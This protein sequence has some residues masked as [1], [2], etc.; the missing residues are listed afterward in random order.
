M[1]AGKTFRA[2]KGAGE[3]DAEGNCEPIPKPT[4]LLPFTPTL[5][6]GHH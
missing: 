1:G 4:V 5:E 3:N 2:R 6:R